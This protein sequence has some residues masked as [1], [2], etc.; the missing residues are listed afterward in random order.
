MHK[1]LTGWLCPNCDELRIEQINL[2]DPNITE[3][4]HNLKSIHPVCK[5][6]YSELSYQWDGTQQEQGRVLLITGTCASGKST[7]AQIAAQ[8]YGFFLIDGDGVRQIVKLKMGLSESD[9]NADYFH[10]EI[11]L[12]IDMLLSLG[13]DIA[14]AHVIL[15]EIIPRYR[16]FLCKR[17]V[18]YFFSVL[19]PNHKILLQRNESRECWTTEEK[20]IREFHHPFVGLKSNGDI[21]VHDNSNETPE[22]TTELFI[23]HFK[24]VKR[25]EI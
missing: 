10:N 17:G 22:E 14:I 19:L 20:W 4:R 18:N 21:F 25:Q 3:Y 15:P 9:W 16:D 6:C 11:L 7:I 12:M 8:Q 24:T 13:H 23:N 1:P 2:F 5:N